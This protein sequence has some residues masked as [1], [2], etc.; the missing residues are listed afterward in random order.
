AHRDIHDRVALAQRVGLEYELVPSIARPYRTAQ[1]AGRQIREA[2]LEVRLDDLLSEPCAIHEID[3]D[4][5]DAI[6][7]D[8]ELLEDRQAGRATQGRLP[9][10]FDDQVTTVIRRPHHRGIALQ[11]RKPDIAAVRRGL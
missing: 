3:G 10:P 8:F 2:A 5:I 7:R 1:L 4:G 11:R 9:R 6:L